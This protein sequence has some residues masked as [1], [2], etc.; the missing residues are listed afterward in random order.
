[1][2]YLI[3][4]NL[5][6]PLFV[7]SLIMLSLCV[8]RPGEA[9]DPCG[10]P[11]FSGP[12]TISLT[13]PKSIV[14]ADFNKDGKLDLAAANN[15][16]SGT[17]SI[18]LGDG[19]GGFA[20]PINF[21]GGRMPTF[22]AAG[23]L[24]NDGNPDLVIANESNTQGE[25]SILLGN[26]AGAF[27]LP[28][29]IFIIHGTQNRTTALAVGDV[30]ADGKADLVM[31]SGTFNS[32]FILLGDGTGQFI[33]F[34]SFSSGGAFPAYVVLKDLNGDGK[35]DVIVSNSTAPGNSFGNIATL[36]GDGSGNFGSASTFA[37]G[38]NPN[39]IAVADFNG[40]NKLDVAV[41]NSTSQNMSVLLGDGAGN[42]SPDVIY[43][44]GGATLYAVTSGDF[45]GDGK[46]DLAVLAGSILIFLGNGAG[47]FTP[48]ANF[49]AGGLTNSLDES[50]L[51]VGDFNNDSRLDLAAANQ[52]QRSVS[53][54]INSC[55]SAIGSQ[56]QF[57]SSLFASSEG[58]SGLAIAEVTRFGDITA[59]AS[60]DYAS[61]D[62][63]AS[64]PQDYA[65]ISGTLTLTAGEI[66]KDITIPIVDDNI[67]EGTETF[68][69]TL[70]HV[71]GAASLGSP[72]TTSV[73][74]D[75]NDPT[76][77]ISVNDVTVIEGDSGTINAVFT[78]NLSNPSAFTVTINYATADGAA[79]AGADYQATSGVLT[80][81]PGETTRNISVPVNG[82]LVPEVNETFFLNLS[83]AS[84][85]LLVDAQGLGTI[86]D[87]DSTCPA[88][89][90][91]TANDFTVGASPQD[92]VV[93]DFNRD[94]KRD[95][96]VANSGSAYVSLLLG[97]GNGGFG[98][99]TNFSVG[100]NPSARPVS[101]AA[102]DLNVDTRLD[103]VTANYNFSALDFSLSILLAN[104]TGGFASAITIKPVSQPRFVAIADF[105]LDGK[106]DLSVVSNPAGNGP[107]SILIFL[108]NGAGG[109]GP[110]ASYAVGT[111]AMWATVADFNSDA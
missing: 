74:I 53:I 62:G 54:L 17:V 77:T 76:P 28:A 15:R 111:T 108:G 8:V 66:F 91:G 69:L 51:A 49:E 67:T 14:I 70:S 24:N 29:S 86:A 57:A 41:T 97:D 48:V 32:I 104:D 65:A 107:S 81:N 20:A 39:S 46:T 12:T 109:F 18:L 80:F 6:A 34:K 88:P 61:S 59:T 7:L 82:D 73:L 37:V 38:N 45:N 21:P 26:G 72:S 95:L 96:A 2:R 110:P 52:F 50:S 99:A 27:G 103:L 85:A 78:V 4:R 93:G 42:L 89:S 105:N 3:H 44:A 100:D 23:D 83:G 43:A 22:L 101:I 63:T 58:G 11:N 25:V 56:L 19:T 31:T 106:P 13:T 40:D 87:N 64:T 33:F 79:T 84:N 35:E 36:L 5:F 68:G 1:M 10:I 90:F 71:T 92:I 16:I 98:T 75:D 102:G 55:G 94:G 9:A 30:N 47:S 60:V